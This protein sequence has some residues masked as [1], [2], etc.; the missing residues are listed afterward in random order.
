MSNDS[1]VSSRAPWPHR[2]AVPHRYFGNYQRYQVLGGLAEIT[3]DAAAFAGTEPFGDIARFMFFCLAFDQIHK[4]GI[5]GDFAELGVYQGSTAALLARHARRLNRCLY[6]M[7]TFEGFDRQDLSG[8]DSGAGAQFADASLDAVR[9]RVGEEN[10]VYIKGHFPTTAAQL[11][12]NG[13]YCLV[14]LDADLYAPI[15]SGL[16]YFYPRMVPGGFIIIH[17]YSSLCWPGAERAV[18]TF[19]A[20]KPECVIPLPDG[21][22]SAVVRRLRTTEPTWIARQQDLA[23]DIWHSAANNQ[24]VMV[25]TEGWAEPEPWGVWGV[26]PLHRITLNIG[27]TASDPVAVDIDVHAFVWDDAAERQVDVFVNGKLAV[28]LTFGK[29]GNRT[30]VSLSPVYAE[31]AHESLEIEFRPRKVAIPKD[32]DRSTG[33]GRPLGVALHRVRIRSLGV[34]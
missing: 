26:G 20:N 23:R 32:V 1:P 17:D 16:E 9:G 22:G 11:P 33:E 24:L 18:D 7:D 12:E 34:P 31:S 10:T 13:R 30:T 14:H 6:L 3:E 15:L 28:A 21:A 5:E 25:L 8:L 27:A 29:Q 19:F 4:E 2:G